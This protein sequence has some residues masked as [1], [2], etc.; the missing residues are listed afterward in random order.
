VLLTTRNRRICVFA[1]SSN[2]LGEQFYTDAKK[3]GEIL[4]Q[5]GFD[6][7]YG[8]SAL[9]MMYACAGEFKKY[10]QKIYG[11]MPEK[12]NDFGV[13]TK[14]CDEFFLTK[15]MR[16]RKAKMDELSDGVLALAGGFGT[17]EEL[18]EMI[19][20]KQLGYNNKPIVLLN[21]D[22]FYN[23]LLKFFDE[24]IMKKFANE[25]VRGL[26]Y[27]AETPEQALEY[28]IKYDYSLKERTK[29]EIYNR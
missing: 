21:T 17:L 8:G 9:G 15:T 27:V 16:E 11:V 29:E 26:Y 2:F 12:L 25:N 5:N 10:G 13:S 1:S 24:L 14:I 4:A 6:I 28:F 20:Q 22:G 19:V 18:S 23:T 3:S 7:V